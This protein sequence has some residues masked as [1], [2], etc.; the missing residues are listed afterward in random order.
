MIYLII[1]IIWILVGILGFFRE[2][3]EYYINPDIIDII[4]NLLLIIGGPIYYYWSIRT[5]FENK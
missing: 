4:L 2:L 5:D 1:G 3:R